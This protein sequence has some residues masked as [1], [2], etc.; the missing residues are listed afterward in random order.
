MGRGDHSRRGVAA[1]IAI[2]RAASSRA[3]ERAPE[4]AGEAS[5]ER[6]PEQDAMFARLTELLTAADARTERDRTGDEITLDEVERIT[7]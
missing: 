4:R 3:G 5:A 7:I 2:W 1:S 6:S